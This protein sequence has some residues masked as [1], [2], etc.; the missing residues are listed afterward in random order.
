MRIL[1]ADLNVFKWEWNGVALLAA[2][3]VDDVLFSP[4]GPGIRAKFFRRIR[5]RFGI[6]GGEELVSQFC[7]YQFRYGARAQTIEMHQDFA[8][9]VLAKYGAGD[10][11][12]VDTPF[13]VG[14]PPLE[15]WD[16]TASDRGTL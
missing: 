13:K 15:P 10:F 16:E 1:V 5:A 6:T 2:C 7:G 12:T 14:A 9:A 4:S 8:R 11:K 3:H